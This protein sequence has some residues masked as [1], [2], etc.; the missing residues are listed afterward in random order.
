[1]YL[2]LGIFGLDLQKPVYQVPRR[3]SLAWI[4]RLPFGYPGDELGSGAQVESGE[5]PGDVGVDGALGERELLSD[6]AI[7]EATGYQ[8]RDLPLAAC[9][10]GR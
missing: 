3:G 7:G 6:P 1:M 8:G 2:V 4:R 9:E 10:H 5:D